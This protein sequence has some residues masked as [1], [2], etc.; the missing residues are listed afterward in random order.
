MSTIRL[1]EPKE[2][3]AWLRLRV[4]LWP[5]GSEAEHRAEIER[6]LSGSA[7]E[8]LAVLMAEDA[9]GRA[10]G[11]VELSI[12]PSAEGCRTSRVAYLEGLYVA[13][14]ARRRGVGR[15]LV[16]A[17]EDWSRAQRCLELASDAEATNDV[18]AA[19]H[20]ALGFDEV[21]LVRCF[22]KDLA[23]E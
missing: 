15:A 14:E 11:F 4:A 13:P 10:I 19:M 23:P 22:R 18:S 8:P 5:D 7:D 16:A 3:S 21:G 17:A 9:E 6:F 1:V 12:R 20:R 2:A